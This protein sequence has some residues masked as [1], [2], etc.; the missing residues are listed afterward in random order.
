[1]WDGRPHAWGGEEKREKKKKGVELTSPI[2]L[3]EKRKKRGFQLYASA[4]LRRKEIKVD[5][6]EVNEKKERARQ[7]NYHP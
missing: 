6:W 5:Q 3:I 7:I 1:V 2:R 4:P